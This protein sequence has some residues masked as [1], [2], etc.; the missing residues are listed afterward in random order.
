MPHAIVSGR[1]HKLRRCSGRPAKADASE[2]ASVRLWWQVCEM[3]GIRGDGLD[4]RVL[5]HRPTSKGNTADTVDS[6]G[7][8]VQSGL[9]IYA[10]LRALRGRP[11]PSRLTSA[12]AAPTLHRLG[13]GIG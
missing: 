8:S 1:R 9:R 12:V 6:T 4:Y 7:A 11:G 5:L 2:V 10:F 13:E 3:A